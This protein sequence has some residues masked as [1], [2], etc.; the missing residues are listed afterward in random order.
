MEIDK[1]V[2]CY[3]VR[4]F[5][6]IDHETIY[7]NVAYYQPGQSIHQPPVW[8]K[9]VYVTDNA[10]GNRLLTDFLNSFVEFVARMNIADGN[11]VV[12]TA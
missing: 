8:E 2:S 12:I 7:F 11:K 9:T 5:P 6:W 10:N 3:K 4:S 1:W